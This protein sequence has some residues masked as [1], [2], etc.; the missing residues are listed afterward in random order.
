MGFHQFAAEN[1][2]SKVIWKQFWL[3]YSS[4]ETEIIASI[5]PNTDPTL[6]VFVWNLWRRI[7]YANF[8]FDPIFTT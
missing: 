5:I 8:D 7:I 3:N 1:S 6:V 4:P 2:D